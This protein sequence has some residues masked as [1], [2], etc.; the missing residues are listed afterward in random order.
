[1]GD[2]GRMKKHSWKH[3]VKRILQTPF[4]M[5]RCLFVLVMQ[6]IFYDK[7]YLNTSYFKNI[8]SEGWTWASRDIGARLRWGKNRYVRWPVSP[9]ID[10]GTRVYFEPEDLYNFQGTGNY[11]QCFAEDIVIGTGTYIAKNV[12]I[13]TANHDLEYPSKHFPGE[14]VIIGEQSWL[15]MNSMILPGVTLGPHTVVGAGA[16]VTHSFPQ[17][18]VVICGN[19][20]KVI[21]HIGNWEDSN[22]G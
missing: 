15:G 21:K 2:F 1:M 9:D 10:C 18:Y 3:I 12:G 22:R 16:V 6:P 13:I 8:Y 7:K 4:A 19:P 11:F 5:L 20:A 17:G 14:K